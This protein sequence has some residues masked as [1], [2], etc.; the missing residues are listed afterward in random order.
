VT[1]TAINAISAMVAPVVLL[2]TGGLLTNGLLTVYSS[3][4]DRMRDMTR[5]RL[6]IRRGPTGERL[7]EIPF[8]DQERLAEIDAQLPMILRRHHLIRN[9]VL[10]IYM[11]I[12]VLGLS[13]IFIAVAVGEHNEDF[14]RVALGLVL[15]GTVVMLAGL[16]MAGLSLARSADAITYA[17]ERT[18]RLG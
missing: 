10:L 17:V 4:N 7:A 11:G 3:V 14:G 8:I 5:E 6:E 12:A 2:T 18:R 1:L 13:I 9:A 15:A 16:L